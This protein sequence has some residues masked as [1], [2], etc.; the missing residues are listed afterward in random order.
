MFV[1]FRA[2]TDVPKLLS[3]L[4][5]WKSSAGAA[6]DSP[7]LKEKLQVTYSVDPH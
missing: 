3:Q 5:A 7:V 6:G 2:E 4:A 1:F